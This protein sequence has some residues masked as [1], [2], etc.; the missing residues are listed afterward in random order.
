MM[1]CFILRLS[2]RSIAKNKAEAWIISCDSLSA[3]LSPIGSRESGSGHGRVPSSG[4]WAPVWRS[5]RYQETRPALCAISGPDSSRAT[6][7]SW[8]EF[9]PMA[10]DD[11]F[12]HKGRSHATRRNA[13]VEQE[14]NRE[15]QRRQG[16]EQ[17]NGNNVLNRRKSKGTRVRKAP[18]HTKTRRTGK[19]QFSHAKTQRRREKRRPSAFSIQPLALLL[20]GGI[21]KAAGIRTEKS[22]AEPRRARR[23]EGMSHVIIAALPGQK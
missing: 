1:R 11:L 10:S 2:Q 20:M 7:C 4:R 16:P 8:R 17:E 21:A 6:C 13:E 5:K 19:T 15:K 23:R 12:P 18:N 3:T 14:G 22:H 9:W